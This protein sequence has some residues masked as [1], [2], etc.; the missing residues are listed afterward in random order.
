[1]RP[2]GMPRGPPAPV[3]WREQVPA[4]WWKCRVQTRRP[5]SAQVWMACG[6][7]QTAQSPRVVPMVSRNLFGAPPAS[8]FRSGPTLRDY[9]LKRGH[10]KTIEG[11]KLQKLMEECFG[12]TRQEGEWLVAS[13]GALKTVKA[14]MEG[15]EKV[16]V[17]SETDRAAPME[18]ARQTMTVWNDFLER[19]TGYDAKQRGKRATEAAKKA[20]GAGDVPDSV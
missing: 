19:A 7:W 4:P 8:A 20:A 11:D 17:D 1:M 6:A 9:E 13:F 16:W 15:K 5:Q 2:G 12:E 3:G 18:V 14:R 10:W